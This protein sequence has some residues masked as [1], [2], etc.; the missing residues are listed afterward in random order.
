MPKTQS[1][2]THATSL[3]ISPYARRGVAVK[4]YTS[5][6]SIF[7]TIYLL[8]GAPPL[9]Q[10]DAA[11]ADLREAFAMTPDFKPYKCLEVDG[12]I[13]DPKKVRMISRSRSGEEEELDAAEG[14]ERS[15]RRYAEQVR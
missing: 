4:T 2:R 12:R 6:A 7:K 3:V 9:E 1:R 11:A 10:Y 8:L 5:I 13:F 14:F 15:H